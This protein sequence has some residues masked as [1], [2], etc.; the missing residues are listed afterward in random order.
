MARS[1]APTSAK[2]R[3][4]RQLFEQNLS[5][6]GVDEVGRG[7]LAGP[8]YAGC[9][10]LDWARLIKLPASDL[11]L[12]RDSKQLSP[13][14]RASIT[15]VIQAVCKKFSVASASVVEI[16]RLGILPACFLAMRRAIAQCGEV[17]LVLVDGKL[18]IPGY[19]G[20]QMAIVKGDATTFSIAAASIL[21][22][23]ARDHFMQEMADI[24]PGYGFAAHVGYGTKAHIGSIGALG[25]CELHRTS[26]APIRQYRENK[27]LCTGGSG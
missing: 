9:A 6:A 7:C 26:F 25:I 1:S 20:E 12:I 22:K 23:T 18:P 5:F 2:G 13:K 8:V 4:E 10:V 3:L 21:A 17:D 24:Y 15:P 16:D 19:E 14:Q 27:S 11:A